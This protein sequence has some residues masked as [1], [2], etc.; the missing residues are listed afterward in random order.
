[1]EIKPVNP[2]GNQSWAYDNNAW[3]QK[4]KKEVWKNQENGRERINKDLTIWREKK[5]KDVQWKMIQDQG[6]FYLLWCWVYFSPC[7]C[8]EVV[9]RGEPNFIRFSLRWTYPLPIP[10]QRVVGLSDHYFSPSHLSL[11]HSWLCFCICR[12][13][14]FETFF[15]SVEVTVAYWVVFCLFCLYACFCFYLLFSNI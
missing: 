9:V 2:K 10:I 13:G 4:A 12:I 15:L 11:W 5:V 7:C 1:M 8:G 6:V 14:A 3:L